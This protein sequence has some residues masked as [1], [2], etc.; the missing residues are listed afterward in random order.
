M[1]STI[2]EIAGDR[3]CPDLLR[4]YSLS[5]LRPFLQEASEV[6]Q[7]PFWQYTLAG[8][9]AFTYFAW[10]QLSVTQLAGYDAYYHLRMASLLLENFF[11][12]F[13]FPY[14]PM[15]ILSEAQFADHH[16]LFHVAI[17][18]FLLLGDEILMGKIAAAA[19][20]AA[21]AVTMFFLLRQYDVRW[22]WMWLLLLGAASEP[23]LYR[24][25]LMRAQ[26]LGAVLLMLSI[27]LT[28]R[29][30]RWSLFAIGFV[31]SWM[32]SAFPILGVVVVLAVLGDRL[33][34]EEW[35]FYPVLFVGGG[36]LAGTLLHPYGLNYAVFVARH[37][38]TK[39]I[40]DFPVNP[41]NEWN[42]FE[43][44]Q[45]L[46][47]SW[48]AMA[49]FLGGLA[50]LGGFRER[51][52]AAAYAVAFVS[53]LMFVLLLKHRRFSEYWP[54]FS[55]LLAAVSF[56]RMGKFRWPRLR[57]L[58]LSFVTLF[59]GYMAWGR[60]QETMR[61]LRSERSAAEI[62][63]ATTWVG[64]N[65]PRGERIFHADWDDF[66]LLFYAAPENTFITGLDPMFMY[67]TGSERY[68]TYSNVT[69]TGGRA[70][71]VILQEFDSR[72]VFLTNDHGNLLRALEND[73]RSRALFRSSCCSVFD[74]NPPGLP[75]TP[76]VE[77]PPESNA[78]A[79]VP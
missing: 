30:A 10:I 7:R 6:I 59:A 16:Y 74:L 53:I 70:V 34:S 71:D 73:P 62:V 17:S 63:E 31:F 58:I 8:I 41:G 44:D 22:P 46:E 35:N 11:L 51:N 48:V 12:P 24:M 79:G 4:S 47:N 13:S 21:A 50:A 5:T 54:L 27:W 1:S 28:I 72:Y 37:L 40:G 43:T 75:S 49:C 78:P 39:M 65:T 14:M 76:E 20:A 33:A 61:E 18:P 36:M 26:G 45:L 2:F 68:E 29:K 19:F 23:F 57:V 55:V 3:C 15:S 56:P 67:L 38:G 64:D 69:Q 77:T 52:R 66:P 9:A 42:P 25:S 60:G 32:Y